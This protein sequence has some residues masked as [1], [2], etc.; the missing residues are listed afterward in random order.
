LVALTILAAA[1]TA[2]GKS[3]DTKA[4]PETATSTASVASAAPGMPCP[5]RR[6]PVGSEKLEK[7]RPLTDVHMVSHHRGFAVGDGVIV[8]TTDGGAWVEQHRGPEEFIDVHAVDHDH[9]WAVGRDDFLGTGNGGRHWYHLNQPGGA[10]LRMVHFVSSLSG[11]GVGD[12]NL[13]RTADGGRSWTELETPCGAEAACLTG[14]EEGW[15]AVGARIDRTTDGGRSWALAFQLPSPAL[16]RPFYVEE[17]HCAGP[18]VVWASFVGTQTSPSFQPYVVYRGSVTDGWTAVAE[19][20]VSGPDAVDAPP[21]GSHAPGLSPVSGDEAI[22]L[23]V[24]PEKDRPVGLVLATA[25][26]RRLADEKWP[27]AGVTDPPAV[28]FAS[29][30][31]GWVVGTA[32]GPGTE[33]GRIVATQDGGRTWQEQYAYNP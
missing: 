17:L 12:G 9:A 19:E 32:S 20:A 22:L 26:G 33:G 3:P 1:C 18:G 30:D 29:P 24:T 5:P 16:S 14:P 15:L 25:G 11:W 13:F 27:V 8:A 2:T 10:G 21:A 28:S 7:M 23:T 4:R 31:V 6:P